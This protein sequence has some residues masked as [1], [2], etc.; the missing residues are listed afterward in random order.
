MINRDSVRDV[1]GTDVY[2]TDGDKIGSA[3]QVYLDNDTGEAA[4]VAVRTGL[5]GKKESFVPIQDATLDGDRL[6]VPFSKDKVKHAPRVDHDR[7]LSPDDEDELYRYYDSGPDHA[8][9]QDSDE[10]AGRDTPGGEGDDAMTRSEERLVPGTRTEQTG[11]ARLRKYTVTEE[12]QVSVPVTREEVR[13]EQEPATGA[14][15]PAHRA[16]EGTAVRGDAPEAETTLWAEQPVVTTEA[17]PVERVRLRKETVAGTE[18]VSGEVRKERI[19]LEQ[20]GEHNG[21]D[22]HRPR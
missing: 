10:A 17:V 7:E 2:S 19:E 9:R 3:G 20:D 5:F 11:K 13:L 15:V 4:W 1:Y 12:R 14:A 21:G 6:E 18:T 16:E 22:D 8:E